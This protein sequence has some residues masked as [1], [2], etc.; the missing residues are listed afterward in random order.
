M[1]TIEQRALEI[2]SELRAEVDLAGRDV[3]GECARIS[4]E[5]R[6]RLRAAGIASHIRQGF[7]Q[8]ADSGIADYRHFWVEL[9]HGAD[10]LCIDLTADQFNEAPL[11][12]DRITSFRASNPPLGYPQR[13]PQRRPAARL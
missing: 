7:M 12:F 4:G 1:D 9:D 8:L 6:R 5:L 11:W 2:A 3:E 10:P 13:N